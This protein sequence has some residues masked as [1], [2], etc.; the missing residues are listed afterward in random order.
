MGLKERAVEVHKKEKEREREENV[1]KA[2]QFIVQA[3]EILKE[4][5]GDEFTAQVISKEP[6]M[7]IFEVDG[8]KFRVNVHGVQIIKKCQKCGTEYYED[9]M[10]YFGDQE[11]VLQ[12]IGKIL[13]EPHNDYDCRRILEEKEGKKE[14][15]A[16]EKLLQALKDFIQENT[17]EYV[18]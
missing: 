5:I 12:N 10:H 16:D 11:K 2:E 14:L 8:I 7:T 18:G 17:G 6:T 1:Q 9:L 4:R 3:K 15:T 13:S